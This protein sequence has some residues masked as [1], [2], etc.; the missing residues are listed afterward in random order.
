MPVFN[1]YAATNPRLKKNKPF[2]ED[3]T[4]GAAKVSRGGK[5]REELKAMG[6]ANGWADDELD[7]R[8]V[9]NLSADHYQ[10]FEAFFPAR[11]EHAATLAENGRLN[12]ERMPVWEAR[13]MWR[14]QATKEETEKA[15]AAGD[16]FASRT[17]QFSRTLENAEIMARFWKKET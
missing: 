11:L 4:A 3:A 14:G 7:A 5:G 16:A 6:V 10:W 9:A 12:A 13:R 17:P 2:N 15:R 8:D 1:A